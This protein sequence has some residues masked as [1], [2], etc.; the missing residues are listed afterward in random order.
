M[1]KHVRFT[2]KHST[3]LF[4]PPA[5]DGRE[6]FRRC[7]PT[8]WELLTTTTQS[9]ITAGGWKHGAVFQWSPRRQ[10]QPK[11]TEALFFM[12][13][14]V[15]HNV[16]A[17]TTKLFSTA[18]LC[19]DPDTPSPPTASRPSSQRTTLTASLGPPKRWV[20]MTSTASTSSTNAVSKDLMLYHIY[21]R[22][23]CKTHSSAGEIMII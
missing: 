22:F 21:V 1:S 12:T 3:V 14:N 13:V 20:P 8:T 11:E 5:Q 16:C 23:C 7:R 2:C 17:C 15:P 18:R 4:S 6:T 19:L 10:H 9:C